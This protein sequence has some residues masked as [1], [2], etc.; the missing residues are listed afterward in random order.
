MN[1]RGIVNFLKFAFGGFLA[2]QLPTLALTQIIPPHPLNSLF[3]A[4]TFSAT[5]IV[6]LK[7]ASDALGDRIEGRV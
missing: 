3:F 6:G 7:I 4:I 1:R 5:V 2:S